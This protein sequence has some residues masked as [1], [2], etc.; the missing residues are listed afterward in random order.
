MQET[1]IGKYI[2]DKDFYEEYCEKKL[3]TKA[4]E[5]KYKKASE[6]ANFMTK[7]LQK[8][9]RETDS[10]YND[11]N[12]LRIKLV[13]LDND[14]QYNTGELNKR[15]QEYQRKNERILQLL[16]EIEKIKEKIQEL[17]EIWYKNLFPS[18]YT[19]FYT[20]FSKR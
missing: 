2:V 18:Q 8:E 6:T 7:F 3:E 15:Q 12:E 4:L 5:S 9:K 17:D 10:R 11:E 1:I 19:K 20:K 16:Q 13:K 14:I